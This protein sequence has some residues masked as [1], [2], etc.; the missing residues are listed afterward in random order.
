MLRISFLLGCVLILTSC[1]ITRVQNLDRASKINADLGLAYLLKGRNE[2]ALE[3]FKK[4]MK[5]NP[6]NAKAYLY[7]A[8]LY[9]RLEERERADRYFQ[10]AIDVAP[11]DSSVSNNYGAF[12]CADKKYKEAFKYFDKALENPVYADR[13]KVFENIGICSEDQG[14]IK[15][16]RNNYVK[17]IKINPKLTTSLLAVALLDFDLGNIESAARYLKFYNR[18][19]RDT[20]PSLW[21]GVLIAKKQNKIKAQ[22]NLMWSLTNK[23]PKSKEAKLLEKLKK[24]GAL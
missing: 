19:G 12:L 1:T 21:L 23:F 7:T 4:A 20:P 3:K 17:A 16:A 11:N 13:S 18:V 14:N 22:R 8:E 24:S 5:Q 15:V 2:Q 6:D 10:Q 9:R